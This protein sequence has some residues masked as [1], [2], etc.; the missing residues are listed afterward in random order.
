MA[1][2]DIIMVWRK[3]RCKGLLLTMMYAAVPLAVNLIFVMTSSEP[4]LI[5]EYGFVIALLLF[6]TIG[7]KMAAGEMRGSRL[8]DKIQKGYKIFCHYGVLWSMAGII[9]VYVCYANVEYF[10]AEFI[11]SQ[12]QTFFTVLITR[13]ESMEGYEADMPV[14][15]VGRYTGIGEDRRFDWENYKSGHY[16][17]RLD[18]LLN[19][20]QTMK[21]YIQH[22][23]GFA[24]VWGNP[25]DVKDLP[26]VQA[27]T[28]YPN[29]GS[30]RIVNN[31]MVVKFSE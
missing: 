17:T 24:P 12:A 14:V 18:G 22:W 26:E 15:F 27:M 19:H 29:D 5:M 7:E 23:N 4:N 31:M 11:Q 28:V 3:E 21:T 2:V 25:D 1:F 20:G 13:I 30:I 8:A 9:S 16:F 10:R 6:V